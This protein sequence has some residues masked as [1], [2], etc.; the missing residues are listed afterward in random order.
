MAISQ[1]GIPVRT[2]DNPRLGIIDDHGLDSRDEWR[3]Q[4]AAEAGAGCNVRRM[5]GRGT[6]GPDQYCA[7]YT[8]AHASRS[9]CATNSA[10]FYIKVR[11]LT[12]QS[13]GNI[14]LVTGIIASYPPSVFRRESR[15][16]QS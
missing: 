9:S 12:S 1:R 13:R 3:V 11:G 8:A 5:C 2:N 15:L 4:V 7:C 6:E 14:N 16:Q 10:V